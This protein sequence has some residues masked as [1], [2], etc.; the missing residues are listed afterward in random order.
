MIRPLLLLILCA[1]TAPAAS[2]LLDID[3]GRL[4]ARADLAYETPV[5]RSEEG[6]PVGN[7][8]MGSL[9]WTTASALK[10][11]INRVDVFAANSE[12]TSFPRADTDYASGCGYVDINLVDA[13]EDV[14][15]GR[16][17]RQHLSVY[18][19]LMTAQGQGLTA[20]MLAWPARDV[21]AVEIDD[22]REQPATVNVDLRMLRYLIQYI[23]RQNY[24]LATNHAVAI[25][26]AEH[27]ATSKLDIRNGRI[28]LL[29]EFR[30][31]DFHDASAV[32]ISVVGRPT[33]AR[34]LNE[35]TVQLS[36]APARGR[37]AIFISSAA[38]FDPAQDVGGLAVRELEAAEAKGFAALHSE[39]AA[40]WHDF[41]AKGFVHLHSADGQADFVERHYTYFLYLIGASS[42]GAYPPRFGG[43]LWRTTGDLSRWG[44][45]YW[46]ANTAAYYRNL[47]PANRLEL[48]DPLFSLYSGMYEACVLAARQEWGSQGIWIP[49]TTFFNGPEKL[50][51]DIAAELQDLYLVRKPWEEASEK[52]RRFAAA[53]N[54]HN[55]RWNFQG[56]GKW[57]RG[58]YIV[59]YKNR[60]IFGHTTHIVGAGA[61]IADLFWQRYLFTM[62]KE[63]LRDRAYPMIKG[64]AE[65]YRHFPNLQKGADGKYHIHRVNSG[66]SQWGSSDT[67]YEVSCLHMIFPL[68]IRASEILEVD[69]DLRLVWQ[70][71]KDNLVPMRSARETRDG[72]AERAGVI[73]RGERPADDSGYG[74]GGFGAFVYG[75]AGAIQPLGAEPELKSRF[76]NFNRLASFIDGAGIGGAQILRNRLRLREGPGAIDAE[77]IGGLSH[78]IHACLLKSG[79]EGGEPILEVFSTW[80][81]DWEAAFTLLAHGAFLVTSAQQNGKVGFVEL[82]SAREMGTRDENSEP[83]ALI[84][85]AGQ[86]GSDCRLRNPWGEDAVTLYRD[87]KKSEN[88]SG[89]LLRFATRKGE[90]I[91]VV[92]AGTTPEQ[93]KR[94]VKPSP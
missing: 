41:W 7:G 46:W 45:Q 6:M 59:A 10:F 14:F 12:T 92:P 35:A 94:A 19:G 44:S 70:E 24:Q 40:W 1:A 42:R 90:H 60:G 69:E 52:F 82:R 11:Q 38:S 36:A 20:R 71:I 65:F 4:V 13:G 76:L 84:S 86:A 48:M 66:E 74:P 72:N 22:Q 25:K 8:R 85:R 2:S 80:P 27:T 16:A 79:S 18:D 47:L 58:H 17:F 78:G 64:A 31:R 87:G 33:R 26:T 81:K 39:T 34:Y 28:L 9:V 37:F 51:D 29:Q 23:P 43:M 3:Y 91:V 5:A 56:D 62:D 93:C 63:W 89:S 83:A 61:R 15:T 32:A 88:L 68:A 77:H 30:E 21:I 67:A 50:P 75:G 54:R 55:S 73:A 57:E 49:E 53:K